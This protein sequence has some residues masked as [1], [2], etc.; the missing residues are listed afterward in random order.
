M[1]LITYMRTDSFSLATEAV[2]QIRQYIKGNFEA[3]Y[4]PKSP[5]MYKTKSKNAQEAHEAIRPTDINRSPDSLRTFLTPE[6]FKLY[7]MI[8]KRAP[9]LPDV[10]CKIR[11]R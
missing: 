1:G 6:Q 10:A 2:M 7:Q 4:L 11:T 3:D 8:W 5:I 9:G